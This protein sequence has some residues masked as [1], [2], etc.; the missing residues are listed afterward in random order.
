MAEKRRL[1][2]DERRANT[3]E[4]LIAATTLE[5][6]EKGYANLN[7]KGITKRSGVTWGAAQHLFGDRENLIY[8]VAKAASEKH[9]KR[10]NDFL[11]QKP[12]K[13]RVKALIAMMWEAYHSPEMQAYYEISNSHRNDAELRKRLQSYYSEL[14]KVYDEIWSRIFADFPAPRERIAAVRQLVILT[15]S[16]LAKR[17]TIISEKGTVEMV[18]ALLEELVGVALQQKSAQSRAAARKR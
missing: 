1:T 13:D 6:A 18:L 5:I 11:G 4:R 2:Q 17:E 15:L 3:R 16:G 14:V 10:L 12:N 7:T 9:I 8:E